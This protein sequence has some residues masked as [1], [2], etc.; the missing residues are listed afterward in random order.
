MNL[1]PRS[2][3]ER[4]LVA[5]LIL[6]AVVA[7]AWLL[8][9]APLIAGFGERA[10]RR[11]ALALHYAHNLRTIGAIPRLRRQA[12]KQRE[13]TRAYVLPAADV[14]AG[15]ELVKARL[16]QAVE[17]NGGEYREGADAEG[18]PGWARASASARLTLPQLVAVLTR[19]RGDAPYLVTEALTVA[20]DEA[21]VTGRA[22]T[23][24]VT[25]DA[26]APLRAPAAR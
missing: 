23:L 18:R 10:Q 25:I 1:V 15:R 8:L 6:V 12:E 26:S 4:R 14:E 17:A 21:V 13:A 20:A 19:V 22:T 11:E 3:R 16:R 9:V 24:D 2:P 7:L 5:L